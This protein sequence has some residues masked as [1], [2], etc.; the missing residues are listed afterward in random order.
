MLDKH[1]K[2][3]RKINEYFSNFVGDE[4]DNPRFLA[5]AI[6]GEAGELA[7]CIKKQWRADF[8]IDSFEYR[9]KVFKE[10]ADIQIYLFHLAEAFDVSI[11]DC[12]AIKLPELLARWP[13]IK[14]D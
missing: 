6:C 3:V 2:I 10:I 14:I 8:A 4:V 12:I 7:D 13:E 9:Q 5:L 1:I 11:D